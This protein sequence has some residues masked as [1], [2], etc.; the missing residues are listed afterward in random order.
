MKRLLVFLC[1]LLGSSYFSPGARVDSKEGADYGDNPLYGAAIMYGELVTE[2]FEFTNLGGDT[3]Y[4][5]GVPYWP[6]RGPIQPVNS[7]LLPP[8]LRAEI[9]KKASTK[10]EL[11]D[12]AFRTVKAMHEEGVSYQECLDEFASL[13]E[14]SEFVKPGSVRK[15]EQGITLVWTDG[16]REGIDLQFNE[17][18]PFDRLGYHKELIDEFWRTVNAGGLVARGYATGSIYCI[19]SPKS[20]LDLTLQLLDRLANGEHLN[21]ED[22]L[23]S[24]LSNKAFRADMVKHPFRQHYSGKE[25]R[26]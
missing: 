6:I 10:H 25:Q 1:L 14:E 15:S 2:P 23:Y 16:E 24:P 22:V 13:I 19:T 5:N 9:R 11:I 21:Q 8:E 4:L 20:H 12:S 3:L 7:P 18:K 26:Q 17:I